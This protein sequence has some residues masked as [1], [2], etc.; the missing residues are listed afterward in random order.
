M[1]VGGSGAK[2]DKVG[3][4]GEEEKEEGICE[5]CRVRGKGGSL[6]TGT[7]FAFFYLK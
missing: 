6:N 5:G 4:G 7:G 1:P 3:K 2:T